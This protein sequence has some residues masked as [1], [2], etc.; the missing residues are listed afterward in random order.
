[1]IMGKRYSTPVCEEVVRPSGSGL[2]TRMVFAVALLTVI[3][4]GGAILFRSTGATAKV[5]RSEERRVGKAC[6]RL[7]SAPW[8]PFH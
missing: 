5:V 8:P 4:C 2:E 7:C 6:L 3:I 1:M